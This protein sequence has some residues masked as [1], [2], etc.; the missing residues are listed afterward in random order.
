MDVTIVQVELD[1]LIGSDDA[2]FG[3]VAA[4]QNIKNPISLARAVRDRTPHILYVGQGANDLAREVGIQECNPE[5]LLVERERIRYEKLKQGASPD[6]LDEFAPIKDESAHDTVGCVCL[7]QQGRIAIAQSTGGTRF[8]PRGRVGDTPQWGSG[9]YCERGVGGAAATGH[10]EYLARVLASRQAVDFLRSGMSAEDACKFTVQMVGNVGGAGGLIAINLDRHTGEPHVGYAFNTPRMAYAYRVEGH[11]LFVGIDHR[12]SVSHN[13]RPLTCGGSTA[14]LPNPFQLSSWALA[15]R[16]SPTH[17]IMGQVAEMRKQGIHVYDFGVGEMSPEIPLPSPVKDGMIQAIQDNKAFYSPAAGSPVLIEAL[18][19]DFSRNFNLQYDPSEIAILPGPKDAFFKACIAVLHPYPT[20]NR[21]RVLTF[22]PI[23]ECF[24]NIPILLTGLPPVVLQTD[25]NFLPKLDEFEE[26]L[27]T[28]DTIRL[29]IVNSPNN[30]SGAVYSDLIIQGISRI[31]SKY[32][33]V[34]ILYDEVYR[35]I[36]YEQPTSTHFRNL[37]PRQT[38]CI[39]GMSKELAATGLRVGYVTGPSAIVA[40]VA[41]I[42]AMSSSCTSLPTQLGYAKFLNEDKD[43]NW[44]KDIVNQLK[45][46]RDKLISIF[47]SSESLKTCM[48]ISAPAG[49]FYLFVNVS[50]LF[51]KSTSNG[52]IV[53]DVDVAEFFLKEARVAVIP[54]SLFRT[55]GYV[56]ICYSRSLEEIENGIGAMERAVAG[57]C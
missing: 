11:D 38:I 13:K 16:K 7:D 34:L 35:T 37:I 45:V 21:R 46:R 3:A 33:D 22:A 31:V 8:K 55:A 10:G 23:F 20:G 12:N 27:R 36:V 52:V 14:P 19:D 42:Q 39:G 29:V 44:R 18:I 24:D 9:A 54:G 53:N 15:M 43:M 51:G 40:T 17:G 50:K 48:P 26:V 47:N 41:A 32:P 4:V 6:Q 2:N 56:R 28:D 1:A 5:D 57:L 30:P 25:L 49:A